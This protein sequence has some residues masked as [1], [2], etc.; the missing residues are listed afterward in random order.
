MVVMGVV[1]V[2]VILISV[3]NLIADI[4][5]AWLNPQIQLT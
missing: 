1:L 4:C 5:I 3:V 2:T